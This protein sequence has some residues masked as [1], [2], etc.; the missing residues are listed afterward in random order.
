MI[1][2]PIMVGGR[3]WGLVTVGVI[4]SRSEALPAESEQRLAD[5]TELLATAISNA[6]ARSELARLAEE[7]AALRRVA[8]LVATGTAA[9]DLF[10]AVTIE[11][12]T[13]LNAGVTSLLRYEAD[14]TVTVLAASSD[15]D[16]EVPPQSHL[17]LEGRSVAAAVL[18]SGCAARIDELEGPPGSVPGVFRGLGMRGLPL[19]RD[20]RALAG[21][22]GGPARHRRPYRAVHPA[23]SHR[24]QQRSEPRT[25]RRVPGPDRR[26]GR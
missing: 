19:G 3:V 25:A 6:Q 15:P 1:G 9:E 4:S 18:S 2:T 13:L 21:L 24:D 22:P 12:R 23:G 10:E 8:T 14:G 11:M 5:F 17:T 7:Q 16:T 26:D 20:P